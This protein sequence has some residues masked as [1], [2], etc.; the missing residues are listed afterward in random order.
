[1]FELRSINPKAATTRNKYTLGDIIVGLA[2]QAGVPL[3]LEEIVP[4]VSHYLPFDVT[5]ESQYFSVYAAEIADSV[6]SMVATIV[7]RNDHSLT[8]TLPVP[9]SAQDP[10]EFSIKKAI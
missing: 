8:I 3:D 9:L 10:E 4:E 5:G 7:S 1:M 2:L 6:Q